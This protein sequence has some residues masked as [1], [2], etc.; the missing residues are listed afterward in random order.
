MEAVAKVVDAHDGRGDVGSCRSAATPELELPRR[1][2]CS[3]GL[4]VLLALLLGVVH[5]LIFRELRARRRIENE[6]AGAR[7]DA[8]GSARTKSEFL[9]NMSHE[10]RT[11]MNGIIGMS[12][13]LMD[14]KLSVE[15][16]E[17]AVTVQ[18]C[19]DSLLTIINDILDFSKIEA[20]KLTFEMLDFDIRQVV[21]STIEILAERAQSKNLEL[22]SL[23]QAG[24]PPDLCGD[25]GRLRQVLLN[26]LSNAIKFTEKGEVALYVRTENV[27]PDERAVAFR[28]RGHG[29]RPVGRGA[30][31]GVPAVCAGGR[32]DHA[33]IRRHGPGTGDFARAG[34]ADGRADGH[35]AAN[36]GG[37][38][39]LVH[40]ALP[41]TGAPGQPPAADGSR[42][43]E[44]AGRRRQRGLPR[45]A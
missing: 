15:Q 39:V 29:H 37:L 1:H 32:L 27:T 21:E 28:G 18:T 2:L 36:R 12:G 17:F 4:T 9:A 23:V 40:R 34:R 24:V 13:L 3:V 8:L 7:D 10:I 16:R 19:A 45:R 25:A 5:L 20:G 22:V 35:P 44:R 30:G 11:P 43:F 31:A 38:D 42:G 14:T 26:L 33:Q 6:L 41:E